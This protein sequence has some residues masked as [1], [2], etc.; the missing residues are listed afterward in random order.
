[1]AGAFKGY[2]QRLFGLKSGDDSPEPD[3]VEEVLAAAYHLLGL[4]YKDG[5]EVPADVVDVLT[6]ARAAKSSE[7][8][9]KLESELWG[10]YGQL[11]NTIGPAV[12]AR[13]RYRWTF[14]IVLAVVLVVQLLNIFSDR[15]RTEILALSAALSAPVDTPPPPAP[16]G[17][18]AARSAV[19]APNAQ[20]LPT[21][22]RSQDPSSRYVT[23]KID[24]A[25]IKML[26]ADAISDRKS[27]I[28]IGRA[29]VDIV[30]RVIIL[31]VVLGASYPD[32]M[33]DD[34]SIKRLDLMLRFLASYL[35]PLLYGLLGGCAFV[36]RKLSDEI[37][38]YTRETRD[39]YTL[40]LMIGSVAGLAVGWFIRPGSGDVS[41]LSLPPLALAFLAGYGSDLFFALL[42][43]IVLT[44]VPPAVPKDKATKA[45]GSS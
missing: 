29:L 10:A 12:R 2:I 15:V 4:A 8:T 28:R 20:A 45:N 42:D 27:Y 32:G 34:I 14:F 35:L 37:E 18:P 38:K 19:A 44:F 43:K 5:A 33:E 9:G 22:P 23:V 7:V 1:M 36:L 11:A 39:R 31:P 40:R 25:E 24:G 26:A 30:D 17:D 13:R 21:A 16:G 6:R 41:L 3:T